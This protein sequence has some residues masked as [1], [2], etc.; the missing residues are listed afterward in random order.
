MGVSNLNDLTKNENVKKYS[1]KTL[2]PNTVIIDGNN[3]LFNR[4]AAIRSSYIREAKNTDFKTIQEPILKQI[5]Y[6]LKA[7]VD[8]V[9]NTIKAIYWSLSDERNIIIVFDPPGTPNYYTSEGILTLKR[10]EEKAR[11]QSQEKL[12]NKKL[13]KV[14]NYI[15]LEYED[16]KDII[17]DVYYQI[18]YILNDSNNMKFSPIIKNE[19]LYALNKTCDNDYK[20]DSKTNYYKS[21]IGVEKIDT[22]ISKSVYLIQS[23][24]EADLTIYNLCTIFNYK[25]IVIFSM[26]SDYFVL[27]SC[28]K[29]VY[30]TDITLIKIFIILMIF[31]VMYL[32]KI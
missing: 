13:N 27:C 12:Y 9:L 24:S 3:L 23:K 25:P 4:Y 1:L 10:D 5:Y 31:G 21:Q 32:I 20:E 18:S 22:N 19:L 2:K 14:L 7:T 26:D 16:S 11:V 15:N 17:T 6:M 29:N 28:L 30:K 8:S